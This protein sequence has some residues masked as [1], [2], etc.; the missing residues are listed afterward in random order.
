MSTMISSIV[1]VYLVSTSPIV[2]VRAISQFSDAKTCMEAIA[3]VETQE[4]DEPEAQQIHKSLRCLQMSYKYDPDGDGP[5]KPV[6]PLQ[7]KPVSDV[8]AKEEHTP[9]PCRD[10]WKRPTPCKEA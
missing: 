10:V 1:L 9:Y 4:K 7:D 2:H 8:P 6:A 5:K 3:V